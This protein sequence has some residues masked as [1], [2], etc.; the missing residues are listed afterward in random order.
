MSKSQAARQRTGHAGLN[1]AKMRGKLA[2]QF[3]YGEC[4]AFAEALRQRTKWPLLVVIDGW[5]GP[6][7]DPDLYGWLHVGLKG[8]D[9]M[10]ID[11]KGPRTLDEVLNEYCEY[12]D[13]R[14]RLGGDVAVI[15]LPWKEAKAKL[16]LTRE[17][18]Y[19]KD[20]LT[21]EEAERLAD[22][23]AKALT[24]EL[25]AERT[26]RYKQNQKTLTT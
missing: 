12:A 26:A 14:D 18:F 9:G 23:W 17:N 19:R 10:F 13:P 21:H 5:I 4:V 3:L 11:A 2:E 16:G 22:Y 1:D 7:E 25:R 8:P 24:E 6:D 20:E 15:E